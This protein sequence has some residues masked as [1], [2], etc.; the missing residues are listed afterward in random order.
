MKH[1]FTNERF[2]KKALRD[3]FDLPSYHLTIIFELTVPSG[4]S[5]GTMPE[6]IVRFITP[7]KFLARSSV[8]AVLFGRFCIS[9]V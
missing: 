8:H 4:E 5:F 3:K 2:R 6:E 7:V 9:T 1:K